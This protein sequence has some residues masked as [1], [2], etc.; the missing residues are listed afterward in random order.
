M[1]KPGITKTQIKRE[2]M[3]KGIIEKMP[4]RK[5]EPKLEVTSMDIQKWEREIIP[6]G[7]GLPLNRNYESMTVQELTLEFERF[8]AIAQMYAVERMTKLIPGET[9]LTK[10]SGALRDLSN[11]VTES[12]KPGNTSGAWSDYIRKAIKDVARNKKITLVE[13][14]QINN[15]GSQENQD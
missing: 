6:D 12:E 4:K 3:K 15:Y 1:P 2:A 9:D 11:I 14:Q 5:V 8:K 13:N 7:S 10:V